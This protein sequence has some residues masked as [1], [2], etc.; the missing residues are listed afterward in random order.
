MTVRNAP[1]ADAAENKKEVGVI[2]TEDTPSAPSDTTPAVTPSAIADAASS[3]PKIILVVDDSE[4]NRTLLRRRLEREG[5]QIVASA[6]G[7]EAFENLRATH[8]DLV[9]LDI[10][11]PGLDGEQV[12]QQMQ[13]DAELR[14]I[15]V[16]MISALDEQNCVN[17]CLQ[18]GARDYLL[19]PFDPVQLRERLKV[20]LGLP[21]TP[22]SP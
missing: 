8:I 10:M 2:K 18:L 9:L 14:L 12:L 7:P 1:A 5:Y 13:E 20:H 15:P 4:T 6:S 22:T 21:P 19:K 11:M 16:I 3:K 17:R